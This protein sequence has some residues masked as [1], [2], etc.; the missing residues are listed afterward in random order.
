MTA[1]T[2]QIL[3]KAYAAGVFPMAESASDPALYW[4]D[5]DERG[6]IPLRGFHLPRSLRKAVKHKPFEIRID[7]AFADVLEFCAERTPT[8][9]ATWI[10]DRI[11]D[12]YNELARMGHAH[13]V[14]A[15]YDNKLVGGLYG[16]RIGAAFFGESMFSRMEN[17]SKI[18]LVHLVARLNAGGFSLLD[19]QFPND[20]LKQFGTLTIAKP[21]YHVLLQAAI[22][23]DAGFGDFERDHDPE[24]VLDWAYLEP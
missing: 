14:E 20:H 19:A 9:R 23:R 4:M 12:L 7:T 15:W 1:I 8:R 6:I 16:V 17:A 10:N 5:P 22:S 13:S 18:C 21:D 24:S 2:P 11:R 3:L